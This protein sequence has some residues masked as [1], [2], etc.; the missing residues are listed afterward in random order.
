[1]RSSDWSSDVFSSDLS[2]DSDIYGVSPKWNRMGLEPNMVAELNGTQFTYIQQ[3]TAY[4]ILLNVDDY[5]LSTKEFAVRSK[6]AFGVGK[7]GDDIIYYPGNKDS[8]DRKST[9][10]NSSH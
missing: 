1:M 7:S 3:E 6:V 10:L 2:L 9:R 5:L 4:E 8:V